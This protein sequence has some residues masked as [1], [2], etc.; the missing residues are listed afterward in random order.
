M[1]QD[2]SRNEKKNKVVVNVK[3]FK[4]APNRFIILVILWKFLNL[5]RQT[6]QLLMCGV[7]HLALKM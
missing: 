5:A 3:R 6:L 1:K 7:D 2:D 4:V